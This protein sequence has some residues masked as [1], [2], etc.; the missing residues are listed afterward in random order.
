MKRPS[1]RSL[2]TWLVI[3]AVAAFAVYKLWFA[4][5]QVVAHTITKGEIVAE[6]MG[7]GTLEARVKTT[8]SARIQERLAEVLVDQGAMVKAGQLLA[9]LDDAESK[10]QVAIAEATLAAAKQTA[11]R[12]RADLARSEAV[13]AQARLEHERTTG[14]VAARAVSQLDADKSAEALRVAEADLNRSKAAIAEAEGQIVVAENN[15][16]FRKEQLAF[17]EIHAPYDGLIIRRDRDAGEMLVPGASLMEIVSLDELW[18]SAWVDETAMPALRADQP[19]RITFRSEPTQSY[20]GKVSRMGRETDRETRE[21]LVDVQ[22]VALPDNWTIGQRAEVYIE[23]ARQADAV[24]LPSAFVVWKDGVAGV[25]VNVDGKAK[26]RE[27]VPGL[28][29]TDQI[30]VTK[31][32]SAGDQVLRLPEDQK[33]PL[34]QNQRI[35]LP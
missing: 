15:L 17:T 4:S 5:Q 20:P 6:V 35:K 24:L 23:T 8:V 27:I 1:I 29:G 32:L 3:A 21:F 16:L 33:N 9:R 31:G 13:L 30:S 28:R 34:T 14:L 7:T 19:A 22:A 26:W 10:Q 2:L 25:F 11:A 18:V 12:V